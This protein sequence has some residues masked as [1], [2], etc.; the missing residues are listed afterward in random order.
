MGS[1][2]AEKGHLFDLH[3]SKKKIIVPLTLLLVSWD[4]QAHKNALLLN[5]N[6]QF[7]LVLTKI[8][9]DGWSLGSIDTVEL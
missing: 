8:R 1:L 5:F 4:V 2:M 6:L 9:R 3:I 7:I